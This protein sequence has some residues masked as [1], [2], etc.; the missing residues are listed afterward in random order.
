M[1]RIQARRAGGKFTR[2]TPE[3]SLGL[4][5]NIH[6]RKANGEWC[7]AFNPSTV[8]S[9]RPTICHACNEP[10]AAAGELEAGQ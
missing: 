6:G 5:M 7:G 4:H 3:N 2:N 8:G 9:E 1:K 10:I